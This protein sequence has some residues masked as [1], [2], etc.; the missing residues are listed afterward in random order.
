MDNYDIND[1][2]NNFYDDYNDKAI[3]LTKLLSKTYKSSYSYTTKY[4][5]ESYPLP[6]ISVKGLCEIILN[7]YEIDINTKI[8]KSNLLKIN[9]NDFKDYDFDIYSPYDYYNDLYEKGMSN[10]ELKDK[11]KKTNYK[12]FGLT[13]IVPLDMSNIS[14]RKLINLLNINKFKY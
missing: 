6:V 10:K 12:N 13:F 3:S 9:F 5:N 14:I 1:I 11:I 2:L 8:S 7:E 4:N